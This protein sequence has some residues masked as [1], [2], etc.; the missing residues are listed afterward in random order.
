[1]EETS[2]R[3]DHDDGWLE[4]GKR[5]QMFVTR[6]VCVHG[7]KFLFGFVHFLSDGR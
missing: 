5:N 4:V 3:A 2:E 1:M 6:M 7:K